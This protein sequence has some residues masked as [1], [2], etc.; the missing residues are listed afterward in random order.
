MMISQRVIY[1]TFAIAM[2]ILIHIVL[3]A[4]AETNGT[5]LFKLLEDGSFVYTP[6]PG[7]SVN[8]CLPFELC[9]R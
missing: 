6:L 4:I 7:L 1:L 3:G 2:L 5:E 8:G 9:S